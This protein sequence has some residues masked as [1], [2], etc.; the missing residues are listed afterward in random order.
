MAHDLAAM[1]HGFPVSVLGAEHAEAAA[2][3]DQEVFEGDAWPEALIREELSSPWGTYLG[4][5]VEGELVAYGGI[6][7]DLEGDLMTLGVKES[8]RGRGLGRTLSDALVDSARKRGMQELIL[9]VRASNEPAIRLY[10]GLGF[11][12][13]G[14]IP[15]YY[16]DPVEDAYLMR[17]DLRVEPGSGGDVLHQ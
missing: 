4:V 15:R 10:T 17:L 11:V 16:R 2:A 3:L 6:K 7:G 1:A 12:P 13:V 9:E 5:W 8:W 14:I